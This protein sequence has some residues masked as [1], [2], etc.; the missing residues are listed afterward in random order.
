MPGLDG[1]GLVDLVERDD[2]VEVL[3]DVEDDVGRAHTFGAARHA[4]T[5]R[6]DIQIHLVLFG[7]GDQLFHILGGGGIDNRVGDIL[8]DA[9]S[10]PHDVNHG[11]AV[12]DRDALEIVRGDIL[13]ADYCPELVQLGGGEAGIGM[14]IH[15][16]VADIDHLLE[17]V[18]G[19]IE[20]FF[21]E[22][23]KPLLGTL[24]ACGV[25]PL[26]D[27]AIALLDGRLLDPLRFEI[28]VGFVRHNL[29]LNISLR[30]R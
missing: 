25:T 4:G 27:G 8:D 20:L 16:F 3:A 26:H 9:L 1:D 10:H 6:I 18:V 29:L 28:L 17:V 24:V 14:E 13:F 5:A 23:V 12:A 19:E 15:L 7:E 11:L 22:L 2:L 21:D 30:W